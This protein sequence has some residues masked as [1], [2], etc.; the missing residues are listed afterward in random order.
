MPAIDLVER[1]VA[2]HG[3]RQRWERGGTLVIQPATL[4]GFIPRAKGVGRTFPLPPRM[5]IALGQYKA[6]FR[7][8]PKPGAFGEFDNGR[9]AL[10]STDGTV[11]EEDPNHR[12]SFDGL[13]KNRHWSPLDAL[14]F[15]GYALSYYHAMPFD[16][17]RT[18]YV[19]LQGSALTVDFP[20][21]IHTHCTRQTFHFDETGLISAHDYVAEIISPWARGRHRWL[22]YENADGLMIART[23][24]VRALLLGWQ[25]PLV[26]L[27][28]EFRA[29][30]VEG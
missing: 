1:S 9:V 28:A 17:G 22:N 18:R 12:A 10:R 24:D 20:P 27:H 30:H 3:G 2:R 6:V 15:F 14:Y 23:R 29:V 19:S 26:A 13:Q 8:Y 25:S 4:T 16:L 11:I 7:D 21:E 5:E